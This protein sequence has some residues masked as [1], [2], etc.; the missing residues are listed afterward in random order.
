MKKGRLIK[1]KKEWM[2]TKCFLSLKYAG[3]YAC[4]DKTD[5]NKII[6]IS[7]G[8]Y[9]KGIL[10]FVDGKFR[11]FPENGCENFLE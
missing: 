4:E 2:V 11:V 8:K 7:F 5:Y 10:V 9:K 6:G 3:K 1:F